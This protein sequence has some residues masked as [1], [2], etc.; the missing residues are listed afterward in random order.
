MGFWEEPGEFYRGHSLIR[1]LDAEAQLSSTWL[2]NARESVLH[3]SENQALETEKRSR[4][5]SVCLRDSEAGRPGKGPVCN[6]TQRIIFLH[7]KKTAT[8]HF[9]KH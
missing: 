4:L 5:R 3:R 2:R 7:G 8:E 1:A 6:A 9:P